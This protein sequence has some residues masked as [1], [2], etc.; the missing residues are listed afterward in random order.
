M[1]EKIFQKLNDMDIKTM[2]INAHTSK[3]QQH[4]QVFY[5]GVMIRNVVEMELMLTKMDG[6]EYTKEEQELLDL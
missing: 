4:F 5:K 1:Q 6:A 2:R 3:I